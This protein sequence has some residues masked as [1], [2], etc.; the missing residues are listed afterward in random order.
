M[1][2]NPP[3]RPQSERKF[4]I[5]LPHPRWIG[6]SIVSNPKGPRPNESPKGHWGN[7]FAMIA[8]T[9][10]VGC[11]SLL[12]HGSGEFFRPK[13]GLQLLPPVAEGPTGGQGWQIAIPQPSPK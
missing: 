9:F 1:P 3:R 12:L 7:I 2:R 6:K 10:L 13:F 11:D 8:P 5:R 4:R